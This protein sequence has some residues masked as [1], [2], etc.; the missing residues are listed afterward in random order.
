MTQSIRRTPAVLTTLALAFTASACTLEKKDDVSAYREAIP[1][2]EAVTV[3][4]PESTGG[5]SRSMSGSSGLLQTGPDDLGDYA[6][7]YAWTR[8]VRDGVNAVTAGVL[9]SV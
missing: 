5:E 3:D 6:Y 2:A 4:G 8:E 1:Q 9:G 7:W